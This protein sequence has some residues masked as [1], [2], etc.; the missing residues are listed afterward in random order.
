MSNFAAAS[1]SWEHEIQFFNNKQNIKKTWQ[2]KSDCSA[3][4][5]RAM[6][7]TAS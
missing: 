1:T 5:V 4:A 2:Q 7:S 3:V 6:L